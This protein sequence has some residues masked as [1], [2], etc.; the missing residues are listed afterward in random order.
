MPNRTGRARHLTLVLDSSTDREAEAQ[1]REMLPVRPA[2]LAQL[3]LR[4]NLEDVRSSVW[5]QVKVRSDL[6]LPE[7]HANVQSMMGW[8]ETARYEF[9]MDAAGRS[10][11]YRPRASHQHSDGDAVQPADHVRIDSLFVAA[12]D[13]VRYNHSGTWSATIELIS[14]DP[15][16]DDLRPVCVAGAGDGSEPGDVT[17]LLGVANSRLRALP[18]PRSTEVESAAAS[19]A[20]A[21]LFR[22]TRTAPTPRLLEL[23]P[24]CELTIESSVDLLVAQ[25]AMSKLTGFLQ[26]VGRGLRLT[27]AGHLPSLVVDSVR[28]ELLR[29]GARNLGLVHVERGILEPTR[30]GA[31]L[32]DDPVALWHHCAARL[33]LGRLE[34]EKDA[35]TLFL[36]ALAASASARQR[37]AMVAE[38]MDGLQHG[39]QGWGTDQLDALRIQQIAHPTVA[40]LDLI[41]AHGP[42][43]YVS[44]GDGGSPSWSRRFARDALRT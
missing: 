41:G 27:D 28:E 29:E 1:D 4:V 3:I 39:L 31:Q 33:P 36:V 19:P 32:A 34:I 6:L 21:R 38:T 24:R 17:E 12:G 2:A 43:Y 23:L 25:R 26:R 15:D 10:W 13:V 40:F 20:I 11:A 9:V 18:L 5:R 16:I 37:E 44:G 7:L 22:H 14:V 42:R 30:I 8:S 35:G